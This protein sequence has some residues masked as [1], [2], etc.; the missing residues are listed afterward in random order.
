MKTSEE[1][2]S[3]WVGGIEVNDYYLTEEKA[4]R[5]AQLFKLNGHDDVQVRK[6][7]DGTSNQVA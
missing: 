2:Y 4:E 6:E 5:L 7:T 1:S 3:V